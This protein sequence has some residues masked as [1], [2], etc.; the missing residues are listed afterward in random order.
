MQ[1]ETEPEHP[2]TDC[3]PPR[4]CG[5]LECVLLPARPPRVRDVEKPGHRERP[6]RG[7]IRLAADR[8]RLLLQ[9]HAG[10]R[11]GH[12][13]RPGGMGDFPRPGPPA[14][15]VQGPRRRLRLVW[16]EEKERHGEGVPKSSQAS[17][18]RPREG[19]RVQREGVHP[20]GHGQDAAGGG[21]AGSRGGVEQR[22][23]RQAV[24]LARV[25][26][27]LE[28]E[29]AGVGSGGTRT[30]EAASKEHEAA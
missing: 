2:C 1:P 24:D 6:D 16:E 19:T 22:E 11:L 5:A 25:Q 29:A 10:M 23:R 9:R 20:G 13:G 28:R 12:E 4:E 27:T 26:G 8:P 15:G 30:G 14:A 18:S 3:L 7:K 21:H 17:G